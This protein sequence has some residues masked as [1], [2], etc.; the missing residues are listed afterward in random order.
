MTGRDVGAGV[1]G[2]TR[3]GLRVGAASTGRSDPE[4]LLSPQRRLLVPAGVDVDRGECS[5]A[6]ALM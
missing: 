5:R 3:E 1:S 2:R 4:A 6:G